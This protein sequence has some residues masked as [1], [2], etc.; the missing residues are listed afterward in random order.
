MPGSPSSIV[1][2]I[3]EALDTLGKLLCHV[4]NVASCVM[5]FYG[6]HSPTYYWAWIIAMSVAGS[7]ARCS[8]MIHLY[9]PSLSRQPPEQTAHILVVVNRLWL[10]PPPSRLNS[11]TIRQELWGRF[12]RCWSI[13]LFFWWWYICTHISTY[14][15]PWIMCPETMPSL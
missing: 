13:T 14:S 11:V 10:N 6:Q 12:P 4:W 3:I 7:P 8:R 5:P 15:V 1:S 2:W 9:I